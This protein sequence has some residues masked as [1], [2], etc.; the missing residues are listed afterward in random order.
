[1]HS[2]AET[3][4]STASPRPCASQPRMK[5]EAGEARQIRMTGNPPK[6][7]GERRLHGSRVVGAGGAR[8]AKENGRPE[9]RHPENRSRQQQ[10][11]MCLN[12]A[13]HDARQTAA[14]DRTQQASQA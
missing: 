4:A 11:V 10:E 12:A 3:I 1:M 6:A 9:G 8:A 2:R 14:G 7:F 5:M 13:A